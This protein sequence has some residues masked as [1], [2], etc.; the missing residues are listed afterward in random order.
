V[1]YNILYH[2]ILYITLCPT[3]LH[4]RCIYVILYCI[5]DIYAILYYIVDIYVILYYIVDVYVIPYYIVDV[6]VILY[7]IVD[8]YVILYYIVDIYMPTSNGVEDTCLRGISSNITV[9]DCGR[10]LLSKYKYVFILGQL[11]HGAGATP[12]YTLGVSYLD[13]N[14][15]PSATSLYVGKYIS[16][17]VGKYISLYR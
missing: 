16:L 6:Y 15:L 8:V 10:G 3:I 12:L 1:L 11:L 2:I 7:Y 13:D 14:L 5:V 9:G 17:Y 4:C